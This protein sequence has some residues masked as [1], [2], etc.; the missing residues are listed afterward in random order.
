MGRITLRKRLILWCFAWFCFKVP[1]GTTFG[2][3]VSS[4]YAVFTFYL[5]AYYER[6]NERNDDDNNRLIQSLKLT[7][8]IIDSGK[9]QL[10]MIWSGGLDFLANE[11]Y[12]YVPEIHQAQNGGDNGFIGV[13]KNNFKIETSI[14]KNCEHR[15]PTEGSSLGLQFIKKQFNL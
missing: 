3:T 9:D 1:E 12:I 2:F 10:R 7:T 13:G 5:S 6:F 11:T 15:I 8:K 4:G 14:F